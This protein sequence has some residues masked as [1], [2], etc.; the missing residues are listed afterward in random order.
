MDSKLVNFLWGIAYGGGQFVATGSNG[1]VIYSTD[2][3]NW[4]AVAIKITTEVLRRV[5]YDGSG[6]FITVG[7][8]GTI[9]YSDDGGATWTLAADSGVETTSDLNSIVYDGAQWVATGWSTKLYSNDEGANWSTGTNGSAGL[10]WD[11]DYNG[12][13]RFVTVGNVGVFNYSFDGVDWLTGTSGT[14]LT[15]YGVEFDG[16]SR[17]IAVGVNGTVIYTDDGASWNAAV[18]S[19]TETD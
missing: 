13:S 8:N 16:N 15:L 18:D 2:G 17:F 3:D 7:H 10:F 11:I 4:T 12:T 14:S 5:A 1:N 9:I 6:R 19:E